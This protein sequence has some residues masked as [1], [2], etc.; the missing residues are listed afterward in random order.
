MCKIEFTNILNVINNILT[1]KTGYNKVISS[2]KY[3]SG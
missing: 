3:G 1:Y 2:Y